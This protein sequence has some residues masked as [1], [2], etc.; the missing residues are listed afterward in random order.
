VAHNQ[1]KHNES[2]DLVSLCCCF[3]D[4]ESNRSQ[5]PTG[6]NP[7]PTFANRLLRYSCIIVMIIALAT[8][9]SILV[10]LQRKVD[11]LGWEG[12]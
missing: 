6:P 4:D 1:P 11:S 3:G 2:N 7:I 9:A 5:D 10:S 12:I 8:F